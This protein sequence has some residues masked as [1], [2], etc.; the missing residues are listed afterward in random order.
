MATEVHQEI[1][2]SKITAISGKL[3]VEL[4]ALEKFGI[5]V[6]DGSGKLELHKH[7]EMLDR[8]DGL[9]IPGECKYRNCFVHLCPHPHFYPLENLTCRS[10]FKL[11]VF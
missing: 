2:G 11:G 5:Q 10:I 3:C 6:S 7:L 1:C 9:Y 8:Q 4:K